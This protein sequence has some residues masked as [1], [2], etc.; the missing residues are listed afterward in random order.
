[1]SDYTNSGGSDLIAR[2][3]RLERENRRFKSVG[4]LAGVLVA[5]LVIMAPT[6]VR[7]ATQSQPGVPLV[8]DEV[9]ARRI[10]VVD[11]TG[12]VRATLETQNLGWPYLSRA[13]L[14]VYSADNTR[15]AVISSDSLLNQVLVENNTAGS[16]T[17][18]ARMQVGTEGVGL[19]L[20][21]FFLRNS[22][23][24]LFGVHWGSEKQETPAL[25]ISRSN[26][27]ASVRIAPGTPPIIPKER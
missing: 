16:G 7:R 27:A 17:R 13:G 9:R 4:L 19:E 20:S 22:G 26:P 5:S 14:T 23:H 8:Q 1:M 24:N 10:V 2:I 15:R 25:E 11:D 21:E 6:G 12:K 3:E 18:Y